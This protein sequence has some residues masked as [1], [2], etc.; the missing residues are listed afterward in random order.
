MIE[1]IFFSKKLFYLKEFFNVEILL[2]ELAHSLLHLAPDAAL[3]AGAQIHDGLQGQVCHVLLSGMK[4][5]QICQEV[6][7][8]LMPMSRYF[9]S[10][11]LTVVENK[12]EC[13]SPSNYL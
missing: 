3:V 8:D 7:G 11:S 13:S 6:S 2:Y 9:I 4:V 12:L 5:G 1:Q 10:S